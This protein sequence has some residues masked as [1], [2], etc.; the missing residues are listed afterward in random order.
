MGLVPETNSVV[1][2]YK[3]IT[4]NS[5]TSIPIYCDA[6]SS[7]WY[8]T[9]KKFISLFNDLFNTM[10]FSRDYYFTN[11]GNS[12]GYTF[13]YISNIIVGDNTVPDNIYYNNY[14]SC[15]SF[16]NIKI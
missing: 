15:K 4:F 6:I 12:M 11:I 3:S 5:T 8:Q 2:Q 16:I 14:N 7:I 9:Q 10:L 1:Q 13:D